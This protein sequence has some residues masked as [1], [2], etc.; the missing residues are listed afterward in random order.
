MTNRTSGWHMTGI[1]VAFFGTV[2]AVNVTMATF[3]VRT[4]GGTVVENSYVASQEFNGWLKAARKQQ[5]LGWNVTSG[6]DPQRH[7]IV[8]TNVDGAEVT[9]FARHPLG[10][11]PDVP[12]AFGHGMRSDRALPSGRWEIYLTVRKGREEVRTVETLS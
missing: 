3:A 10:R 8:T 5:E 1:L 9:G 2:I 6:L 4:F 7:V 11:A 12:L